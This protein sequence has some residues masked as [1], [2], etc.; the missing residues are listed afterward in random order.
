MSTDVGDKLI[1]AVTDRQF[2]ILFEA[3]C[4]R[5]TKTRTLGCPPYEFQLETEDCVNTV[6][7]GN[8]CLQC[9]RDYTQ[10]QALLDL[11]L[12]EKMEEDIKKADRAGTVYQ[13]EPEGEEK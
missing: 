1:K 12:I 8:V 6:T 7:E 10:K 4:E 5:I 11:G 13:D 2:Q 3:S 9:W